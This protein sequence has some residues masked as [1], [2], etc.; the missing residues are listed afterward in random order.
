M[1]EALLKSIEAN[2]SADSKVNSSGEFYF[3]KV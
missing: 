3:I 2:A 1:P